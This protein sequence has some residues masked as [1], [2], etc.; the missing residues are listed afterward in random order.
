M[1]AQDAKVALALAFRDVTLNLI[2]LLTVYEVEPEL[3]EATAEVLGRVYREH[4]KQ[5]TPT[6]TPPDSEAAL[7]EL[8]NEMETA[9][10]QAA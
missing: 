7:Q 1:S 8:A 4:L 2:G 10:E 5:N 6:G 9:A 3:V